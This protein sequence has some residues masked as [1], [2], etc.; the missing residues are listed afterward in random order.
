MDVV[1]CKVVAANHSYEI[2]SRCDAAADP[3]AW[4]DRVKG[5]APGCQRIRASLGGIHLLNTG[6]AAYLESLREDTV[7][8]LRKSIGPTAAV[9]VLDAPNQ[10]NV[11]DSL[12]WA[13]ELAYLEKLGLQIRYVADSRGY[14]ADDLRT[15]MPEG[16]VLFHG[17]GNFGDL[18]PSHQL[19]RERV[20]S[21]LREYRIVLLPQSVF[22]GSAEAA[23]RANLALSAHPDFLALV[24]DKESI[25][26][27]RID[28]PNVAVEFCVDMAFGFQ[29]KKSSTSKPDR[30]MIIGRRD[31]EGNSGLAEV[32]GDW[33]DMSEL[34]R[35]D[36]GPIR[37]LAGLRWK[38]D[39]AVVKIDA[40]LM[41][42]SAG[43]KA[44][45]LRPLHRLAERAIHD[46]NALNIA[47]ALHLYRDAK[48]IIVDRLHA[49]VLAGLLGIDHIAL[50]NSYRKIGSV[51]DE[52]SGR[53][54]TARYVTNLDAAQK[55]ARK[56]LAH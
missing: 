44:L 53:L 56:L 41:R 8:T 4:T 49:H 36:W 17:G 43:R 21:D 35:T 20:V 15:A 47:S 30:V 39:R 10:R 25:E 34:L 40:K 6:D 7:E 22:F 2:A 19:H 5:T 18:W 31:H 48:L 16:V 1:A 27:A 29:P 32:P 24:R 33:L 38:F 45:R 28:L 11:G 46:I 50:D 12:I 13:G 52:Y 9:A 54:S 3:A 37:G 42:L 51:F 14:N 23:A 26:R 55:L